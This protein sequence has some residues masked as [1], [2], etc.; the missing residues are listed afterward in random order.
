MSLLCLSSLWRVIKKG[1]YIIYVKLLIKRIFIDTFGILFCPI[2]SSYKLQ[3]ENYDPKFRRFL[4]MMAI[5]PFNTI[6]DKDSKELLE[7]NRSKR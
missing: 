4:K 1:E 7:R 2:G 6:E 5:P 3:Q